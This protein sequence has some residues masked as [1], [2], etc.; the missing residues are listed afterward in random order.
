MKTLSL[1]I[2]MTVNNDY[3]VCQIEYVLPNMNEVISGHLQN[4][5]CRPKQV[6]SS[7]SIYV[8]IYSS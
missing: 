2:I 5:L 1:K 4:D 7:F 6:I 3:D 8:I